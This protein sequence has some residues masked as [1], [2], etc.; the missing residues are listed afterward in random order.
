MTNAQLI[1][2]IEETLPLAV[3]AARIAKGARIADLEG[4]LAAARA[5]KR[6][7]LLAALDEKLAAEREAVDPV[8]TD[9]ERRLAAARNAKIT[10]DRDDLVTALQ[11]ALLAARIANE[12]LREHERVSAGVDAQL[13]FHPLTATQVDQW[14]A[15]VAAVRAGTTRQSY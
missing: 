11:T 14:N 15:H 1:T 6:D 13:T 2:H 12:A 10:P 5:A 9:L 7:N 8:V 4:R 3:E